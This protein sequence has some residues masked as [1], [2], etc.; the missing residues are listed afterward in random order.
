MLCPDGV[1]RRGGADGRQAVAAAVARHVEDGA[2]LAA[3]AVLSHAHEERARR[4]RVHPPRGGAGVEKVVRQQRPAIAR[5]N[6][7]ERKGLAA[8]LQGANAR[9][10]EVQRVVAHELVGVV[11]VVE[12]RVVQPGK[13]VGAH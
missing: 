4:S 3:L 12:Q 6:G 10:Q 2:V 13:A 8:A 1:E 5:A 7:H 11:L 9:P